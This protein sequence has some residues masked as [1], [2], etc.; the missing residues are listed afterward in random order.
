MPAP[1]PA[2]AIA[3]APPADWPAAV[4][5]ALPACAF[6]PLLGC[7][8]PLLP[9]GPPLP[10]EPPPPSAEEDELFDEQATPGIDS[11]ATTE[12]TARTRVMNNLL[13]LY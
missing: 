4:A 2:P 10:D 1:A 13:A 9:P 6:P 5:P 7:V 8:S 11:M 12:K 3:D